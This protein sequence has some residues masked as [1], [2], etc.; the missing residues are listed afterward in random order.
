MNLNLQASIFYRLAIAFLFG[1]VLFVAGLPCQFATAQLVQDPVVQDPVAKTQFVHPGVAHS[2][3]SI[4]FVK[5]KIEA[6]EAPWLRNWQRLKK[7]EHAELDWKPM[8]H[9]RVERGPYGVLMLWSLGRKG[10]R[11]GMAR[12]QSTKVCPQGLSVKT[13]LCGDTACETVPRD[14]SDFW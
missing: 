11:S 10:L 5:A 12:C 9:A 3:Q 13:M 7:S 1:C 14:L 2:W 8:P 4:A 6:K